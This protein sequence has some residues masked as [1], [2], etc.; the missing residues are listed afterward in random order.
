[1]DWTENVLVGLYFAVTGRE[2]SENGELWC[3][4]HQELNWRSADWKNC[5]PDSPPVR[6]LAAAAFLKSDD[7]AEL[8]SVLGST[9]INGPLALIPPLQFPR[10]AAQMS[11]FTIHPSKERE[12]QIEFLL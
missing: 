2:I 12:A 9:I 11:R 4:N 1:M 10:M 6:Y 5:F 3:M 8:R 7:L